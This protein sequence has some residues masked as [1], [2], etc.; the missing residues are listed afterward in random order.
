MTYDQLLAQG[1]R[2]IEML[3]AQAKDQGET[4]LDELPSL[5][6]DDIPFLGTVLAHLTSA[7]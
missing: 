6:E 3:G 2:L 1:E 4:P 7:S 5:E